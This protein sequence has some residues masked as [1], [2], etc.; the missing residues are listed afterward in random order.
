MFIYFYR[1]GQTN[2]NEVIIL[3]SLQSYQYTWRVPNEHPHMRFSVGNI[4]K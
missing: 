2:T 3:N 1:F 4:E